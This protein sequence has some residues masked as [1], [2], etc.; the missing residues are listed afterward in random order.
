MTRK[1]RDPF[2]EFRKFRKIYD[3]G[4]VGIHPDDRPVHGS[5]PIV[6]ELPAEAENMPPPPHANG[7]P[8]PAESRP[9]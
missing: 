9:N 2:K 7:V 4:G 8:E 6:V 5:K 3:Q 1:K